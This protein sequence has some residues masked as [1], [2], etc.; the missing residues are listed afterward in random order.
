[1][2]VYSGDSHGD[3]TSEEDDYQHS[4]PSV[5]NYRAW[6]VL[7]TLF[8]TANTEEYIFCFTMFKL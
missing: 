5:C 2:G 1:M 6:S 7:C 4:P 8:E 3:G